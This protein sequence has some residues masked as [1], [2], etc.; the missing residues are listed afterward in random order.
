[1]QNPGKVSFQMQLAAFEGAL[2]ASHYLTANCLK[3]LSWQHKMLTGGPH[4][5]KAD[6]KKH[7]RKPPCHGAELNWKYGFRHNDVDVER[8]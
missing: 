8:L 5:R 2:A 1:M 4:R 3:L 6:G 7:R